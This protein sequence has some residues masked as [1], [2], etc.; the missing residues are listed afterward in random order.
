MN[1]E[2]AVSNYTCLVSGKEKKPQPTQTLARVLAFVVGWGLVSSFTALRLMYK[3]EKTIKL[4]RS[5]LAY[6]MIH[7]NPLVKVHWALNN[8]VLSCFHI[9]RDGQGNFGSLPRF[10]RKVRQP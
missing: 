5:L 1:T 8:C 9:L 6:E 4:A 10:L 3:M 7:L 2:D